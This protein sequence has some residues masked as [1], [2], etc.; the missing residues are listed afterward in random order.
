MVADKAPITDGRPEEAYGRAFHCLLELG[1][2][3]ANEM[4]QVV[5]DLKFEQMGQLRSTQASYAA[6]KLINSRMYSYWN[7]GPSGE[8]VHALLAKQY[9]V[10]QKSIIKSC[11]WEGCGHCPTNEGGPKLLACSSCMVP[12]YCSKDCQKADWPS[13]KKDCKVWRQNTEHIRC[14]PPETTSV[15]KLP[16]P[17]LTP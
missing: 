3:Y 7:R 6:L 4:G 14:G 17:S 13:H 11:A 2:F 1:R 16:A 5:P 9:R 12:S 15:S 8:S 10:M